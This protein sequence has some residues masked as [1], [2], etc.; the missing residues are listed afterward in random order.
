MTP[1]NCFRVRKFLFLTCK[2]RNQE[3]QKQPTTEKFIEEISGSSLLR[4]FFLN[5]ILFCLRRWR[6]VFIEQRIIIMM[7]LQSLIDRT[8]DLKR[9]SLAWYK[10]IIK[11]SSSC[12]VKDKDQI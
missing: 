8:L 5:E 9:E 10:K 11:K 7:N 3:G 12:I 1:F 2:N 6:F 4:V